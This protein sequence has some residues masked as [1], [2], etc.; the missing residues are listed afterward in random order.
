MIEQA[1]VDQ[2]ERFLDALGDQFVGL[3]RF[4]D[5]GRV[6]VRD[7][8]RGGIALQSQLDDLARMHAGAVDRAAK[9]LIEGDQAMAIVEV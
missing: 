2:G 1:D 8:D 5:A 7:D 4:R 9:Q 3:T 6:I